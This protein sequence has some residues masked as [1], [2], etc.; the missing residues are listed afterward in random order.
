MLTLQEFSSLAILIPLSITAIKLK[1]GDLKIHLFFVLLLFGA[2]VD[3]LGFLSHKA[4]QIWSIHGNLLAIYIVYEALFFLWIST[5]FFQLPIRN[6]LRTYL[7]A[8]FL[9]S[10]GVKYYLESISQPIISP[11]LFSTFFLIVASFISGFSLL[12]MSEQIDELI[13]YPWFWVLSGI[14]MYSFG[15]FFI[16]TL[17]YTQI[18]DNIWFIRNLINIIQYAFFVIGLLLIPSKR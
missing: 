6:I 2:V 9:L 4:N 7:G 5:C 8:L 3:G 11:S 13:S 15:T 18:I 10:F 12:R 16:E 1:T 17:F 14:F